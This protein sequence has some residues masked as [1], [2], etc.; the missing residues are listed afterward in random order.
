M[1][2]LDQDGFGRRAPSGAD[3]GNGAY[4]AARCAVDFLLPSEELHARSS[5]A[6][7][8]KPTDIGNNTLKYQRIDVAERT[9]LRGEW[10]A[11]VASGRWR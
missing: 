10:N 8:L 4:P 7:E 11:P 1:K 6:E 2:D 9:R 5:L 3:R